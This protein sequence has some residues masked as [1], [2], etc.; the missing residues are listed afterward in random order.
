MIDNQAEVTDR[1][2][3][4][5]ADAARTI[6]VHHR[7]D[8]AHAQVSHVHDRAVAGCGRI[9]DSAYT[10]HADNMVLVMAGAGSIGILQPTYR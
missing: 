1:D 4:A 8:R 3:D 10:S 5:T 7:T 2:G 6:A 9:G